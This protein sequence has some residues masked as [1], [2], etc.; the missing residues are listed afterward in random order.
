[1]D[2][3]RPML[4]GHREAICPSLLLPRRM[5]SSLIPCSL[6]GEGGRERTCAHARVC[7]GQLTSDLEYRIFLTGTQTP[8]GTKHAFQASCPLD[9]PECQCPGCPFVCSCALFPSFCPFPPSGAFAFVAGGFLTPYAHAFLWL[10]GSQANHPTAF[11][12]TLLAPGLCTHN[13]ERQQICLW[14]RFFSASAHFSSAS[15]TG[16]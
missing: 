5:G 14:P 13:K 7:T 3:Q 10:P 16:C 4:P 12:P 11:G 8:V 1:M 2:S 15:K 9:D 6:P